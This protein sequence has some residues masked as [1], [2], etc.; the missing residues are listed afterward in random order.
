M[1]V[2]EKYLRRSKKQF[3]ANYEKTPGCWEWNGVIG[4]R[5]YGKVG[6][7]SLAHRRAYEYRHGLIP[8]GMYVCHR[9]DNRKCV[10][11]DH[12]FLGSCQENLQDMTDKGRRARGSK[13]ASSILTEEKVLE[14]RQNRLLGH[15]YQSLSIRYGISWYLVRCIC[16]NR[17]WKHVP[18][19]E[20]C[21]NYI[22]AANR[23][24]SR[25]VA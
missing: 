13:I 4:T 22:C 16:K 23:Y 24:K 18:L 15:E 3:E 21:K 14:I 11:P 10:N 7:K 17:Q 20:E 8:K 25:R 6:T 19:G 1:V 2:H 12:L 9:C 5:G